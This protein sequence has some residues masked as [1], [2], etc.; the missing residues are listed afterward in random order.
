MRFIL[1][2]LLLTACASHKRPPDEPS[3]M[4]PPEDLSHLRS[5]ARE[6]MIR[7][8]AYNIDSGYV[9]SRTKDG[10]IEHK[11]DA[12]LWTGLA[13]AALSCDDAE[14]LFTQV[15]GDILRRGGLIGRWAASPN[16]ERPSSRDQVR[17]AMIGLTDQAMRCGRD[18][19]AG[20]AWRLHMQYVSDNNGG[21][22]PGANPGYQVTEFFVWPWSMVG[23]FFDIAPHEGSKFVFEAGLST[24]A[25]A[26]VLQKSA[27][28][29]IH[30]ATL[31]IILADRVGQPVSQLGYDA[32]CAASRGADLGLTEWLCRRKT[33]KEIL[34]AWTPNA[35][36]YQWQR[37][38]WESPDGD[39]NTT[40]GVDFLL[41]YKLAGGEY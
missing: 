7:L 21:L 8:K 3:K 6:V 5:K 28:Y 41:L 18:Y 16:N 32:F 31:D 19:I 38:Q 4:P 1:F 27:A 22:F 26:I 29:P 11:G 10:Q 36:E 20:E 2:V 34:E 23:E 15:T 24:T 33:A 13:M 30:L 40:P 25:Q 39:G 37:A 35:Y 9:I 17:G 14:R 12:V